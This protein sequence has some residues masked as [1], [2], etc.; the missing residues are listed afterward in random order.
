MIYDKQKYVHDNG[1]WKNGVQDRFTVEQLRQFKTCQHLQR[2]CNNRALLKSCPRFENY[3]PY[4]QWVDKG[5]PVP[6]GGVK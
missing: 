6:G 5:K 4:K 2:W 1:K 3:E